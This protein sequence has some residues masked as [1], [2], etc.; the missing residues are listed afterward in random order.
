MQVQSKQPSDRLRSLERIISPAILWVIAID[1]TV[2]VCIRR[3]AK[4]ENIS[5]QD[6]FPSNPQAT[7]PKFCSPPTSPLAPQHVYQFLRHDRQAHVP[8]VLGSGTK[9]VVEF[10]QVI[11][12]LL[13]CSSP[14]SHPLNPLLTP[15][16][17]LTHPTPHRPRVHSLTP[18]FTNPPTSL[19]PLVHFLAP[20]LLTHSQLPSLLYQTR[21][22][23]HPGRNVQT[24]DHAIAGQ[25]QR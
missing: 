16:P 23:G 8:L 19:R 14:S 3:R 17:S 1:Q 21:N 6:C 22:A 13:S 12:L 15:T 11:P 18:P 4:G 5:F 7:L 20:F 2:S 10:R 24:K 25:Q 9:R